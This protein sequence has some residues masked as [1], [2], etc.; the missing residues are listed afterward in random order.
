MA[1]AYTKL[2]WPPWVIAEYKPYRCQ[3]KLTVSV[4][5]GEGPWETIIVPDTGP[6]DLLNQ[7]T[8]VRNKMKTIQAVTRRLKS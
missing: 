4:R 2:Y 1:I 3:W 8:Q 5:P 6:E 7:C